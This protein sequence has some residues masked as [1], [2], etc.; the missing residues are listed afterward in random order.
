MKNLNIKFSIVVALI[1]F[2]SSCIPSIHPLYTDDTLAF[3]Q[4]LLGAWT[5]STQSWVDGENEWKFE[6]AKDD[7]GYIVEVVVEDE[8]IKRMSVHL[9]KLGKEYYFDF[10]PLGLKKPTDEDPFNFVEID[11]N[12]EQLFF[13]A[14]NFPAHTFAK[15]V[16]HEKG[17]DL[18]H[19]N[20]DW[21]EKKFKE[22]KIRLKRE[23]NQQGTVVLT[24]PS[25]DLQKFVEK[26]EDDSAMIEMKTSFAKL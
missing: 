24:A 3:K 4:N 12:E 16:F 21:L 2:L 18:L 5:E 14:P 11:S 7:K 8:L 19:F 6:Q 20:P 22:K 9:V 25:K 26:Y 10:F 17:F 1:C 23:V 15:V 13:L